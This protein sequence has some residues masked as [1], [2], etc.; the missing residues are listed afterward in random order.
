M[1]LTMMAMMRR[2][3]TST[4]VDNDGDCAKLSSLLMHRHL[5][6]CRDSVVALV[7]MALLRSP[8]MR[9]RLAVVDNDGDG[10]TGDSDYDDFDDAT[11]FAVVAMALLPSS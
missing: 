10:M 2:A 8:P 3:T 7:M 11:D 4:E 1:T 9:R 6:R 5:R